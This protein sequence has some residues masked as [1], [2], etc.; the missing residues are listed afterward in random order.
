VRRAGTG[1]SVSVDPDGLHRAIHARRGE[2]GVGDLGLL[3]WADVRMDDMSAATATL[4][5]LEGLSASASALAPLEGMEA[6]WFVIGAVAA[7]AAGLPAG[8]V[9]ERSVDE[10]RR[11]RSSRTGLFRHHGTERLRARLPN[12]ATQIYSLLALAETARHELADDALD[13]AARLADVLIGSR[14]GHHGW[15]WLFD[16]ERGG[17]VERYEVYSVHQDAMAPMA[18][19]ALAEVTG[20]RG[21]IDA[22]VEGLRWGF[23]QNELGFNFYDRGNLF[24]HR[25]IR[26][27][28]P[29]RRVG[30]Y[31]NTALSLARLPARI[32]PRALEINATCR[33]YHLGWILEAWSGRESLLAGG[34]T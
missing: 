8:T 4:A 26:R 9:V 29:G 28:G 11:R 23:G 25:S 6:A 7:H 3:L 27:R 1:A 10:L 31:G 12:F 18:L 13:H 14:D 33:P 15:P 22:A 17:V 5:D 34:P 19:L 21:Y 2:L 16:S 30:L 24:A 32:D 20:E